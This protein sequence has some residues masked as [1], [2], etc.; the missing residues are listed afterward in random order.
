MYVNILKLL[1]LQCYEKVIHIEAPEVSVASFLCG[2]RFMRRPGVEPGSTAWKAT[3][4]TV[5]PPTLLSFPQE[6]KS[7][8]Q[9]FT[10]VIIYDGMNKKSRCFLDCAMVKDIKL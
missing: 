8:S 2:K 3:M 9:P 4:L 7:T 1:K 6:I 5:T 10:S